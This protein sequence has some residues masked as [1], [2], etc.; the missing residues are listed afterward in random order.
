MLAVGDKLAGQQ[1]AHRRWGR[2]IPLFGLR[3][4]AP[5]NHYFGPAR[6]CRPLRSRPSA[7]NFRGLLLR[8]FMFARWRAHMFSCLLLPRLEL[9][10]RQSQDLWTDARAVGWQSALMKIAKADECVGSGLICRSFHQKCVRMHSMTSL[11]RR[12]AMDWS[13]CQVVEQVPG[14]V[15][16]QWIVKGT[17][18]LADGV[19][20]N[21]D[22]GYTPEELAALSICDGCVSLERWALQ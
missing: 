19:L 13:G 5:G 3:G 1:N 22:A 20:E 10:D 21:A 14:K 16:G 15:S 6:G 18:I 8:E 4:F 9:K 2:V 7:V 12:L 11:A 17:R